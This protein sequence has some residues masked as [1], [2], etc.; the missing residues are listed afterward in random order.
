[1][2]HGWGEQAGCAQEGYEQTEDVAGAAG[3]E[4]VV[5]TT[6]SIHDKQ[7]TVANVL[8]PPNRSGSMQGVATAKV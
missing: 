6:V 8:L 2:Y 4:Q 5:S 7:T 3:C 1:M